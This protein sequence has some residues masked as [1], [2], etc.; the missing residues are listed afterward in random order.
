VWLK[1]FIRT[2][3]GPELPGKFSS[4]QYGFGKTDKDGGEISVRQR[5]RRYL[6]RIA[7]CPEN[8]DDF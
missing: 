5:A 6:S 3:S 7:G 1:I 8:L 2:P 4:W